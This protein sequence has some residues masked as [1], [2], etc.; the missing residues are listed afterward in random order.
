MTKNFGAGKK[1]I[2]QWLIGQINPKPSSPIRNSGF[3]GGWGMSLPMIVQHGWN[4]PNEDKLPWP[5]I[6]H[7]F[8]HDACRAVGG[9]NR[10]KGRHYWVG[11]YAT[12]GYL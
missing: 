8:K 1:E 12:R 10:N 6:R 11:K 7:H 3:D 5:K 4:L 9:K 2:L